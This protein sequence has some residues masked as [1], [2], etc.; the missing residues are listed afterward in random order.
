[1]IVT[2]LLVARLTGRATLVLAALVAPLLAAGARPLL[3]GARAA[4]EKI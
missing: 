2:R 1:M 4:R 3:V